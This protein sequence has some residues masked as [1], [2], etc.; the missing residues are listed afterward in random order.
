MKTTMQA[1]EKLMTGNVCVNGVHYFIE[2]P[3]GGIKQSGNGKDIFHFS[4]HD[5]PC[6]IRH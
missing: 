2:L 5:L 1:E 4:L 3:Y 6:R